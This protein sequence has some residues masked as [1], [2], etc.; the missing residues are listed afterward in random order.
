MMPL[1]YQVPTSLS[2]S[3]PLVS[4][5]MISLN[6]SESVERAVRSVLNQTYRNIEFVIQDGGSTD[7]TLE[8]L[9]KYESKD[10]RIKL[11]SEKD[12]GLSDALHRVFR[13][14]R[15]EII[16]SCWTDEELLPETV[17]QAVR[18]FRQN[19]EAG[20]IHRDVFITD[21]QGNITG[22]VLARDISPLDYLTF[23]YTPHFDTAFFRD[24][25]LRE[26]GIFSGEW[27][28]DCWE[29]EIWV[30]LF[31]RFRVDYHPGFS[32]KYAQYH[33]TQ[34]S[35][36]PS[37]LIRLAKSW[38]GLAR[39][40]FN[41]RVMGGD[42]DLRDHCVAGCFTSW[43]RHFVGKNHFAEFEEFSRFMAEDLTRSPL[44][45]FEPSVAICRKFE[46][47]GKSETAILI[48][49]SLIRG[50]KDGEAARYLGGLA[51]RR[52]SILEAI[53]FFEIAEKA[54][55]ADAFLDRLRMQAPYLPSQS[56]LQAQKVWASRLNVPSLPP[57]VPAVAALKARIGFHAADW[58]SPEI[59]RQVT[60][61]L[62]RLDRSRFEILC[63]DE[64]K[65]EAPVIADAQI[66][67]VGTLSDAA[68]A[69]L[70]RSHGLQCLVETAGMGDG[71]R[72]AALAA[73]CASAQIAWLHHFGTVGTANMDYVIGDAVTFPENEAH[74]A[75]RICRLPTSAAFA[76]D[77]PA[78]P[79]GVV[80]P[81]LTNQYVTFGSFEST[82]RLNPD[83]IALWVQI[84]S[85]V[86]NSRLLIC[87]REVGISD[88]HNYLRGQFERRGI[89]RERILIR[90]RADEEIPSY[91]YD[92]IDILLDPF[93]SG[94]GLSLAG[95]LIHGIPVVTMAGDRF[96]SRRGASILASAGYTAG[97]SGSIGE[98]GTKAVAL[99]KD[100]E[101]L[102]RLREKLPEM[103][104]RSG[105]TD[106][107][108][109]ARSW[110]QALGAILA[111]DLPKTLPL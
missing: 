38:V 110:E 100:S 79:T 1:N 92:Q 11:V 60:P 58:T 73:R 102:R 111:S 51:T 46:R 27:S 13:R 107:D 78:P 50:S 25:A 65:G 96:L 33:A 106:M 15:G 80:P 75:E 29:S 94:G 32:G 6:R 28:L 10:P 47:A 108:R 3:E 20:V 101:F 55:I 59:R 91:L 31:D 66:F 95:A 54:G 22:A 40:A 44:K 77:A 87:N 30:R 5:M 57:F 81:I 2:S 16:G 72:F 67:P 39:N 53:S 109:F 52:G 26:I 45:T 42:V 49:Q 4:I 43:V 7:G 83:V 61:L 9:R 68:F 76:L 63:Y 105:L 82:E 88:E 48:A 90:P 89:S 37:E 36:K 86:P 17:A 84:L 98:Y 23:F 56:L 8:V 62:S 69:A 14:C 85:S 41:S 103:A 18:Y 12:N 104:V 97:I 70:T 24:S 99:A 35:G 71:H 34:M 74:L 19:P 93:P 64:G 21:L